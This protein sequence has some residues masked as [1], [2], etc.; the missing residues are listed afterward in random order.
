MGADL[1]G[2]IPN[3]INIRV[4]I[5]FEST[6]FAT[7]A[8][9]T[10]YVPKMK[11]HSLLLHCPVAELEDSVYLSIDK[12]LQHKPF[13]MPYTRKEITTFSI[14]KGVKTFL[15]DTLFTGASN[16]PAKMAVGFVYTDAFRGSLTTNPYN[17]RK[18][19]TDSTGQICEIVSQGLY[20][21][22]NLIDGLKSENPVIDFFKMNLY[23]GFVETGFDNGLRLR[24]YT[25]GN[26]IVNHDLTT[27]AGSTPSRLLT[28]GIRVGHCR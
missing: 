15:S 3:G 27:S 13:L 25:T 24:D 20:I 8:T 5:E 17:F 14:N 22:G 23:A 12:S 9:A 4:E 6:K 19:F 21:N 16:L 26:Y 11:I 7:M 1:D 18:N 10:T 2:D 28:S